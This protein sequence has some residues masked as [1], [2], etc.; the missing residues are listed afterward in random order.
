MLG[1]PLTSRMARQSAKYSEGG[2][3]RPGTSSSR[4]GRRAVART[5]AGDTPASCMAPT[6]PTGILQ[7]V[8]AAMMTRSGGY[9]RGWIHR[10]ADGDDEARRV[11]VLGKARDLSV[12]HPE[13]ADVL[14]V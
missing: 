6:S 3:Y 1:L 13:P 7:P 4:D 8:P 10:A 5:C 12:T 9:V 11:Q 2:R 14:V